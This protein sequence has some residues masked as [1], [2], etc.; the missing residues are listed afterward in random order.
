MTILL[1]GA[2]GNAGGAVPAGSGSQK[3]MPAVNENP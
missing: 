3:R 1:F 2:T